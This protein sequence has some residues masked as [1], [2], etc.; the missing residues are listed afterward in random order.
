MR[1]FT[2]SSNGSCVPNNLDGIALIYV[3]APNVKTW[4]LAQRCRF[5]RH[6][7][8]G[9]RDVLVLCIYRAQGSVI[10]SESMVI[11]VWARNLALT[12]EFAPTV[13]AVPVN[14]IPLN[15][16]DA[17][18]VSAVSNCQKM[19]LGRAPPV[20]TIRLPATTWHLMVQ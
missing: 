11:A 8:D 15:M 5:N 19:F 9:G 18:M 17:P 10:V 12:V 13:T 7:I 14:T 6:G 20:K 3:S 1:G 4:G 16:D 2:A